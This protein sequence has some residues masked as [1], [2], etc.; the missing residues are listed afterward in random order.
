M[1][2][3]GLAHTRI[4]AQSLKLRARSQRERTQIDVA[5]GPSTDLP[6]EPKLS[7][8]ADVH[9]LR[10][11]HTRKLPLPTCGHAAWRY[12][13][14]MAQ[15]RSAEHRTEARKLLCPAARH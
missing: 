9:I 6:T 10:R 14:V 8:D 13:Y 3:T 15:S 5:E 2:R 4:E 7:S 11:S 12:Y 1:C